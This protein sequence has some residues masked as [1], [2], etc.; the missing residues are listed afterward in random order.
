MRLFILRRFLQAIIAV[1]VVASVVF[2]LA[3]LASNPLDYLS[4]NAPEKQRQE[5]AEYW[6]L[7]KPIIV[8]YGHYLA[9]LA[10]GDFGTSYFS[11]QPALATV[12]TRLP[13]TIELWGVAML[14]ALIIGIPSGVYAAVRRGGQFD[15]I[16]RGFAFIGTAAPTFWVGIMAIYLFAVALG[17]LPVAGRGGFQYIVMPSLVLGWSIAAGVLRLTRSSMLDVLNT[18]YVTMARA[19]GLSERVVIWKHGFKNASLPVLTFFVLLLSSLVHGAVVT[20]MVFAWPGVG[21]LM[22]Q[23]VT[24]GD[25]A[26][27]QT[28]VILLSVTFII[29]NLIVDIMYA[30][31]NPRIRYG[32]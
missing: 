10:Q 30:Y 32:N 25:F 17:W 4:P 5:I 11:R 1:F 9:S 24:I 15:A 3:R 21:R 12:V 29:L 18:D 19:K 16:G 14:I 26:I 6:G 27:V 31:L 28:V 7:D 23:A 2:I 20:E 22:M 13:A 8:Q